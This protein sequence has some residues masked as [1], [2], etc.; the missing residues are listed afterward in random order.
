MVVDISEFELDEIR[1]EVHLPTFY[2]NG[3]LF[4]AHLLFSGLSTFDTGSLYGHW[5]TKA[6]PYG[7]RDLQQLLYNQQRIPTKQ[8]KLVEQHPFIGQTY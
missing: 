3:D 7:T 8:R 1:L 5:R 2:I 4:D 6:K